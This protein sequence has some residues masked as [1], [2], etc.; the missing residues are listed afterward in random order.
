M[1]KGL[2][3]ETGR[4][5]ADLRAGAG[6]GVS[7]VDNGAGF[8]FDALMFDV[9]NPT[10]G[11]GADLLFGQSLDNTIQGGGGADQIWGEDGNDTIFGG[12]GDDVIFGGNGND[13][14]NFDEGTDSVTGGAGAD[15]FV[16]SSRTQGADV[17][18][19]F[20]HAEGDQIDLDHTAF[21]VTAGLSLVQG[22]TFLFGAG[23]VPT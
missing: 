18:N 10:G 23:V 2:S 3:K 15:D 9:E 17:V 21:G 13:V 4:V 16:W 19:D 20:S 5:Y 8:V 11:S 14:I 1:S 7:Y 12:L 6:F 22:S